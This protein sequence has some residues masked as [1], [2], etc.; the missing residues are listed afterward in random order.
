MNWLVLTKQG[1]VA[2]LFL[3]ST[4]FLVCLVLVVES[5]TQ[6]GLEDFHVIRKA[7]D[8]PR[9]EVAAAVPP[10]QSDPEVGGGGASVSTTIGINSTE[11]VQWETLP[12]MGPHT[13]AAIVTYR[14]QHG[15]FAHIDELTQVSGIGV[16][17]LERLRPHLRLD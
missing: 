16:R 5:W 1:Q 4:L 8:P 10:A 12:G 13:A 6:D 7:V 2:V 17:T 3:T 15:R 14:P 11:L 9:V